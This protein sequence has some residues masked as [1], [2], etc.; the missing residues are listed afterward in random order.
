[1]TILWYCAAECVSF[2]T[3]DLATEEKS[4]S[5]LCQDSAFKQMYLPLGLK[6]LQELLGELNIHSP[7]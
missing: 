6:I 1:M 3:R 4:A 5:L 2:A 7:V